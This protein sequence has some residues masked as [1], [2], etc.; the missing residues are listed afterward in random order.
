MKSIDQDSYAQRFSVRNPKSSYSQ[1]NRERLR[2]LIRRRKVVKKV[3][4]SLGDLVEDEAFEVPP[5]IL[6][7]LQANQ[8]AWRHR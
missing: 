3:L 5:D 7:T 4:A 1:A 2:N 6:R 8:D